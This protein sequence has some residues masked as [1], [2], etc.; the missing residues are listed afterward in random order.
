MPSVKQRGG[1]RERFTWQKCT[2]DNG[3]M[4]FPVLFLKNNKQCSLDIMNMFNAK[5]IRGC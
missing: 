1:E 2:V 4:F 3:F 5:S